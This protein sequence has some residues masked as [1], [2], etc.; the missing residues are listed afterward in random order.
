VFRAVTSNFFAVLFSGV[1]F[2]TESIV[3]GAHVRFKS[4]IDSMT[5][6]SKYFNKQNDLHI[7]KESDECLI[8]YSSDDTEDCEDDIA[9]AHADVDQESSKV[10]EGGQGHSLGDDD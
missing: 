5:S 8:S 10:E 7:L 9:I 6:M 4:H 1:S 3:K 2:N